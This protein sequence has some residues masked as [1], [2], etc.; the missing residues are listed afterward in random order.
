[1][2][3]KHYKE[4]DLLI[5][6]Q[7]FEIDTTKDDWEEQTLQAIKDEQEAYEVYDDYRNAVMG[8]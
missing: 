1:M 6:A 5:M 3:T 4:H 2:Q 8:W 7:A